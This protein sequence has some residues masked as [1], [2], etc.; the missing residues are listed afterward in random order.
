MIGDHLR[1]FPR[2]GSSVDEVETA[3]T[4]DILQTLERVAPPLA[5]RLPRRGWTGDAQ[6]EA[7]MNIA[8]TAR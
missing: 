8:M 7:E 5:H 1:A 6:A 3:F 4:T 2:S